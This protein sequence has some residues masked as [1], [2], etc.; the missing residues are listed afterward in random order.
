MFGELIVQSLL[1]Q[2][3]CSLIFLFIKIL[4]A[5][6]SYKLLSTFFQS[7]N[8]NMNCNKME[9]KMKLSHVSVGHITNTSSWRYP[10]NFHFLFQLHT[11]THQ[12]QHPQKCQKPVTENLNCPRNPIRDFVKVLFGPFFKGNLENIVFLL[13]LF[14]NQF[15]IILL[16]FS[17]SKIYIT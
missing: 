16:I 4:L 11:H 9:N 6:K 2:R 10:S 13:Q 5:E 17:F 15:K 12:H 14:P 3:N 8:L 1:S 7:Y